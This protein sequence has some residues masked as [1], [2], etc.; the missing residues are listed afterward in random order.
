MSQRSYSMEGNIVKALVAFA[1]L[2]LVASA[3]TFLFIFGVIVAI[4]GG[5]IYAAIWYYY[6][7]KHLERL[8][9]ADRLL[10][11]E[12]QRL[13]DL[14]KKEFPTVEDW[15]LYEFVK[16]LFPAGNDH[17]PS[18]LVEQLVSAAYHLYNVELPQPPENDTK[19]ALEFS[20]RHHEDFNPEVLKEVAAKSFNSLLA[21]LPAFE[22]TQFTAPLADLIDLPSA[23]HDLVTPFRDDRLFEKSFA[24]YIT[25][26]R[27][28][29]NAIQVGGGS[30]PVYPQDFKSDLPN[31]KIARLYL[32]DTIFDDILQTKIPFGF[33]D[34]TRTRHHWCMGAYGAGKTTYLRHFLKADLER[35]RRGE[36]SL[37]VIDSKKLIREMR[38]LEQFATTLKDNVIIVDPEHP[39]AL[40][41]FYLPARQSRDV[42]DYMLA[43]LSDASDLQSGALAFLTDAAAVADNPSLLTMRNFFALQKG[44]L[45]PNFDRM[46]EETQFWFQHTFAT[47]APATKNGLHQR[48]TNFMKQN[49]L[50]CKMLNADRCALNLF[51]ELNDGGKVLLGDTDNGELGDEGT[52]ILGRLFIALLDQLSSRRTKLDEKKLKPVFVYMDEAQDYIKED[53]RFAKILEKARAQK[54]CMT[55]AHH[56]TGQLDRRNEQSLEQAGIVSVVNDP[57]LPVS[58]RTRTQTFALTP[59]QLDF[60]HE[61]QMARRQYREMRE[62]ITDKYGVKF[63]TPT[64][65]EAE[66]LD[67]FD[68]A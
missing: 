42:I 31:F 4:I 17:L 51:D 40:N 24:Y 37:V 27:F 30:E 14:T 34:A 45:P 25:W 3:I 56:H 62:R 21:K 2:G 43:N 46:D 59:E 57:K 54:V 41:P 49:Q 53:G 23:I 39:V 38:T 60:D 50:L 10:E 52:N 48:L 47:L 12:R 7:C 1:A 68:R 11:E 32:H 8:A 18:Q 29:Q 64:S 5:A 55:V 15:V 35:V 20:A 58:V 13:L 65:P 22:Q 67:S 33:N 63:T 28:H 44:E 66:V 6:H 9:E 16:E 61:P 36:C 19:E 26:A